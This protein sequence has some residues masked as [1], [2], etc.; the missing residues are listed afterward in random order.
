MSDFYMLMQKYTP[1]LPLTHIN[2]YIYACTHMT[3]AHTHRHTHAD[4][5]HIPSMHT[6]SKLGEHICAC[7]RQLL[8]SPGIAG[9]PCDFGE[10]C[11]SLDSIQQAFICFFQ[12]SSYLQDTGFL[13][14]QVCDTVTAILSLY[15][16]QNSHS[17][18]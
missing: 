13:T 15:E 3:H 1:V 8:Q 18:L 17:P 16:R 2:T 4:T 12:L 14:T 5:S 9:S 11:C 10:A 7:F 6:K